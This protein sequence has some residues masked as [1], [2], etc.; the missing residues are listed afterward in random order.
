MLRAASSTDSSAM[1]SSNARAGTW[2]SST[3]LRFGSNSPNRVG[4]ARLLKCGLLKTCSATLS[5]GSPV[6]E[7]PGH[8]RP[9]LAP[10]GQRVSL[11]AADALLPAADASRPTAATRAA[12]RRYPHRQPARLP[13]YPTRLQPVV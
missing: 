10:Y 12:W 7:W 11:P 13:T 6:T 1:I 3:I 4:D 9:W 2:I 8:V 5:T